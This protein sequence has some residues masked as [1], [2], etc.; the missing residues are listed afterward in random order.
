MPGSVQVGDLLEKAKEVA[1]QGGGTAWFFP[2]SSNTIKARFTNE[3]S[4]LF[5]LPMVST[6]ACL[7]KIMLL[8]AHRICVINMSRTITFLCECVCVCVCC[9][10]VCVLM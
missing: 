6:V 3:R 1:E 4:L 5:E 2:Q 8:A 9:C 7:Q 10:V